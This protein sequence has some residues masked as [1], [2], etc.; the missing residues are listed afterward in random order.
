MITS[1]SFRADELDGAGYGTAG[2]IMVVV[3]F[4][5]TGDVIVNDPAA[6]TDAA[7]RKVYPRRQF[8]TVWLRTKRVTSDGG[9]ASGSGGI[10]YLI[11]PRGMPLPPGPGNW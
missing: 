5:R 10:V 1:Q 11:R 9:V 7:V 6:P 8:E 2:H 4:T 3:G